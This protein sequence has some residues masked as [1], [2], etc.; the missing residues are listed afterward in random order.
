MP[1]PRAEPSGNERKIERRLQG[2]DKSLLAASKEFWRNS[3]GYRDRYPIPEV[4]P[5]VPGT[6]KRVPLTQAC[7]P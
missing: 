4:S 5:S 7:P 2:L 3:L 6:V 1:F